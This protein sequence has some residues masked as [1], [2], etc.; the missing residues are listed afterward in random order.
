M[1]RNFCWALSCGCMLFVS[2]A[3]GRA[4]TPGATSTAPS[5]LVAVVDIAKVFES[6]PTFKTSLESLQQQARSVDLD[7]EGKKKTLTQRGQ[8]LT[9]LN[10]ASSAYCQLE[11]ELARQ[12]ADLQV[13][14]RQVKKDLLQR[15]ALQYYASY[16]EI[17]KTVE[18][19]AQQHGIGLVLRFDSRIMD[20]EDPQSVM[21]GMNRAVVMQRN[22]DI[23]SMVIDELRIALAQNSSSGTPRR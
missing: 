14:A 18:R 15:E 12:A 21:Q 17:L 4:Q 23:T 2:G 9:D 8:Q 5:T 19:I 1:S 3:V 10:P 7:L 11:S 13:Q 16:N 22:L 20:P 6:H